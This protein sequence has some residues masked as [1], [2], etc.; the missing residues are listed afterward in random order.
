MTTKDSKITIGY[1]KIRGLVSPIKFLLA[2]VKADF[3]S[4]IYE[5]KLIDGKWNK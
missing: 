1:W 2:I 5:E 4:K 3:E